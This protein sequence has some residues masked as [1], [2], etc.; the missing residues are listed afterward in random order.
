[1]PSDLVCFVRGILLS[2]IKAHLRIPVI[3][4]SLN[5]R[6]MK[7]LLLTCCVFVFLNEAFSQAREDS[8][9]HI[10]AVEIQAVSLREQKGVGEEIR[11]DS[12]QLSSYQHHSIADLL[13]RESNVFIK[14]YGLGSLA[15]I[16]MP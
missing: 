6:Q 11:F 7:Q 1:M 5:D 15:S 9:F 12:L 16:S 4:Q 8:V 3:L 2:L 14:S 13:Q 10:E